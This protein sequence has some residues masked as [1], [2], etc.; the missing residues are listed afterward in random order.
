MSVF[1]GERCHGSKCRVYPV[2]LVSENGRVSK[3]EQGCHLGNPL[4][5]SP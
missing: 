1:N 5:L 3:E 4:D 2:T